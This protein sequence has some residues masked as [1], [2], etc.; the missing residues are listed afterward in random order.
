MK[1]VRNGGHMSTRKRI[2]GKFRDKKTRKHRKKLPQ[3]KR[4]STSRRKHFDSNRK[5]NMEGRDD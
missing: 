2:M 5:K 4:M 1:K 3:D